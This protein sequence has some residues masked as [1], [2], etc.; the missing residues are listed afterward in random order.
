[1]LRAFLN[2]SPLLVFGTKGTSSSFG[3]VVLGFGAD[4]FTVEGPRQKQCRG[5]TQGA[6]VPAV[7]AQLA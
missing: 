1:M 4:V 2:F 5:A 3:G 7:V 6:L